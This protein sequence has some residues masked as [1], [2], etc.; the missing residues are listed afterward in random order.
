MVTTC[1]SRHRVEE[2][3][4][5][6]PHG[7]IR[8]Q[9][10]GAKQKG[11]GRNTGG[12]PDLAKT[13]LNPAIVDE[14]KSRRIPMERYERVLELIH[15]PERL[16]EAW[17]QVKKNAG[18]AGMDGMTVK[19]FEQREEE[20]LQLI[21]EKLKAGTYRFKPARRVFIPKGGGK[22]RALGIPT[23]MDRVVAQ[24]T[25]L[26]FQ[27][28]FEPTFTESNFGF[29]KGRSQHQARLHVQ[30]IVCEGY[31][32]CAAVDLKS[33]F[34]EIPHGLI[35][36]LIRRSISDE[37]VVTL[38]AR[39]LKSGVMIE[40]EFTKTTKGC[41]QGSPLS[42]M[43]SN[44]VLNEL[45][46]ELEG[47][48]LRYARWADDFVILARSERAANRILRGVSRYLEETLELP[49]NREKS[50][51]KEIKRVTFLGF[52]ILRGKIRV[53]EKAR[54]KFKDNVRQL[55]KRNN[56]LSMY[57]ILHQLSIYLFGWVGYFRI[58]EFKYLFRDLDAWIRSRVRSMQLKKWK[59]PR[60]FQRVLLRSGV[61]PGEAQRVWVRM[62]RWQSV[63]RKEVRFVLNNEWF[64]RLGLIF[65]N[66]YTRGF[67]HPEGDC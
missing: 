45:D 43:L 59:K 9:R 25:N 61:K 7:E 2:R 44:I 27:G 32:W 15:E 13:N 51:A 56:G 50:R 28:I 47:R 36:R 58:Q 1:A 37:R 5:R 16:Y 23:V 60:K 34:D 48:G 29:R 65:L 19:E 30:Q 49:V 12:Y 40:G 42:P 20:L 21:H 26:V 54:Q 4:S 3:E 38:I 6:K 11:S 31:Q 14:G 41:P 24:S 52:Q 53:S 10:D 55:T 63:M 62:N 39:A 66:D 64:R 8:N 67:S 35:L 46:Q 57:Q 33:F 17:Q 18:A 22:M